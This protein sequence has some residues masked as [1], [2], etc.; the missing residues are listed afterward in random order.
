MFADLSQF[1]FFLTFCHM[2]HLLLL[3][4]TPSNQRSYWFGF[5]FIVNKR[6]ISYFNFNF[7]LRKYEKV[8][9]KKYEKSFPITAKYVLIIGGWSLAYSFICSISLKHSG[10][11]CIV[12]LSF[13]NKHSPAAARRAAVYT[14]TKVSIFIFHWDNSSNYCLIIWLEALSIN[15]HHPPTPPAR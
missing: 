8:R 12:I 2:R 7:N 13:L 1:S 11:V 4:G 15:A 3:Q 6:P 5:P 14:E 10:F 9:E